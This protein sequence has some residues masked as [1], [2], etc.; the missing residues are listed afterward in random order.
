[1]D[2]VTYDLAAWGIARTKDPRSIDPLIR[3]LQDDE[4]GLGG[5]A[6]MSGLVAIGKTAVD[7]LIHA[8]TDNEFGARASAAA[9]LGEIRDPRALA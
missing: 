9:T 5:Q 1:M 7:P 8:L 2:Y 6:A 3:I 4:Y